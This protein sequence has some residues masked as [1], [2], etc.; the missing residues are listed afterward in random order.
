MKT[1]LC[2]P[3][4]S[5]QRSRTRRALGR[6]YSN[7]DTDVQTL[8][9]AGLVDTTEGGTRAALDPAETKIAI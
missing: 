8:A 3:K 4:Q 1:A 2:R 7:V 9:A 5:H 6:D